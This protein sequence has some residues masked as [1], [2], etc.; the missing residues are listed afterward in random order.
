MLVRREWFQ[1]TKWDDMSARSVVRELVQGVIDEAMTATQ[2]KKK[3]EAAFLRQN[4]TAT[5]SGWVKQPR[6]V[7]YPTGVTEWSGSFHA[8][9]AGYKPK[10]MI[11][12]GDDTYVM[13]R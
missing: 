13:V 12:S 4:P 10:I 9:A 8:V 11:A 7:T 1:K 6:K 3:A 2:F 5:I